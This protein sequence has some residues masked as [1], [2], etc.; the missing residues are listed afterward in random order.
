MIV[1]LDLEKTATRT[2][3]YRVSEEGEDLY[4]DAGLP[5]IVECLVAAIEGLPTDVL[6]VE[7]ALDGIVS[8]TYPLEVVAA[9]LQQVAQH[10]QN[11]TEAIDEIWP[12][13]R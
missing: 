12:D 5:G 1:R 8:G 13:R 4:D 10:A 7:L 9:N 2:Y 6:A 3:D 11:T